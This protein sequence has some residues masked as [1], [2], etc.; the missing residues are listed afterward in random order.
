MIQLEPLKD[1][2]TVQALP[3]LHFTSPNEGLIHE[4]VGLAG[5]AGA[6]GADSS[7]PVFTV[8][9]ISASSNALSTLVAAE[10]LVLSKTRA[11]RDF[12]RC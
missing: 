1:P 9:Q 11:L 7:G 10:I 2:F 6:E 4:V 5:G 8:V 3:M 12:H